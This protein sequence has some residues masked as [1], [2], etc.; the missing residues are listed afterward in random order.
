MRMSSCPH[1]CSRSGQEGEH[2]PR[3]PYTGAPTWLSEGLPQE[4][5]G[6]SCPASQFQIGMLGYC[7]QIRVRHQDTRL[8]KDGFFQFFIYVKFLQKY[9]MKFLLLDLN[10]F[11]REKLKCMRSVL[12]P[13]SQT[14]LRSHSI[15][16]GD[17]RPEPI[18][19]VSL[20]PTR[21][22]FSSP[23][24]LMRLGL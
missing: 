17:V 23:M 19:P 20:L 14:V 11:H 21:A 6:H 2:E 7:A 1:K 18:F 16:V 5:S 4:D 22:F 24:A 10:F 3:Q 15:M 12:S 9:E 8:T 13:Q